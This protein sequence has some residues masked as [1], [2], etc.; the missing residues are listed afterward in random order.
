MDRAIRQ[1]A[2]RGRVLGSGSRCCRRF[3]AVVRSVHQRIGKTGRKLH[4]IGLTVGAGFRE[5]AMQM[6]FDG[7]LG[8]PNA[9]TVSGTPPTSTIES[10][11]AV[12]SASI[13][14]RAREVRRRTGCS[15]RPDSEQ[16][17]ERRICVPA[18]NPAQ[19]VRGHPLRG[20]PPDSRRRQ[21]MARG[22]AVVAGPNTSPKACLS[23]I[24]TSIV[25]AGWPRSARLVTP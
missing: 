22:R 16:G 15:V 1:V 13:Q 11:P 3:S 19:R 23:A 18:R 9:S 21:V 2:I 6:G 14:R 24:S 25:D 7:G 12:R 20:A 5:H 17:A 4:Q 8:N 10:T